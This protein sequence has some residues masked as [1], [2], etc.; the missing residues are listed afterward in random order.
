MN[1]NRFYRKLIVGRS[2]WRKRDRDE[3]LDF[4][5]VDA[6]GF[7]FFCSHGGSFLGLGLKH[8]QP[9][10]SERGSRLI[11]LSEEAIPRGDAYLCLVPTVSMTVAIAAAL[12]AIIFHNLDIGSSF[13][14]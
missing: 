11:G 8:N 3:I 5:K 1:R 14:C 13:P 2:G 9:G 10:L 7:V 6:S 4:T 12:A